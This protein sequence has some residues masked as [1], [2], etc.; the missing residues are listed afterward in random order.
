MHVLICV[1]SMC[2]KHRA[3]WKKQARVSS[4]DALNKTF[5]TIYRES[6]LLSSTPQS[7]E[8]IYDEIKREHA[9]TG[10]YNKKLRKEIC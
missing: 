4:M 10:S 1:S 6:Q 7:L 8:K 5:P 3:I 2:R 9:H